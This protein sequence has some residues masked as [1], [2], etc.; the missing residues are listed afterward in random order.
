MGLGRRRAERQEQFW[1]ATEAIISG[2]AMLST[3]GS[4]RCSIR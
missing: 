1:I 2:L 4:T 3:I